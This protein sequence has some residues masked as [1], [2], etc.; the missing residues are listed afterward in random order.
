M[1]YV[2]VLQDPA[3]GAQNL[4]QLK[5]DFPA[6]KYAQTVDAAL[7][8]LEAQSA[9]MKIQSALKVGTEFPAFAVKDSTGQPL[10][11]ADYRGKVV[12][13]D[14]WAMWC[15]PCLAE[16]PNVV[17]AYKDFHARGFEIIGISLDRDGDG[18]KLAAFNKEKEMPWRQ[19]FD[20][21]YWQN[22]L[23]QKYGVN[24]IPAT[25]LLD[26]QGRIIGKD[27][28]GPALA[29]GIATCATPRPRWRDKEEWPRAAPPIC[30]PDAKC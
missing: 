20:G 19:F 9:S 7:A 21:K 25:Y 10:A 16:L 24:A 14:F 2:Q 30:C 26:A 5:Q 27:L 6:S 23:A 4:K 8:S 15:G 17:Q 1:L 12:M 22:E 18:P 11:L 29:A 13:L 28:R 3:L